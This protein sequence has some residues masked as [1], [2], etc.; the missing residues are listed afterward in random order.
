MG[1]GEGGAT[2]RCFP[3]GASSDADACKPGQQKNNLTAFSACQSAS[4]RYGR[5]RELNSYQLELERS[6][7]SV[8]H[9][10]IKQPHFAS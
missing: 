5:V 1:A 7:V 6:P 10:S 9:L 4:A 8:T 2:T 3:R